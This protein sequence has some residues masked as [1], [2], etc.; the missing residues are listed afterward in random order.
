MC[1]QEPL[2]PIHVLLSSACC[3]RWSF[4]RRAAP[5]HSLRRPQPQAVNRL[6]LLLPGST[7][8]RWWDLL[9][10]IAGWLLF[11]RARPR[12]I[13][14]RN[15]VLLVIAFVLFVMVYSMGEET[16]RGHYTRQ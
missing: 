10:L 13:W 12:S 7:W 2:L 5:W 1:F 15:A 11:R 3:E 14:G 8:L 16:G 9:L 6:Q 4:H